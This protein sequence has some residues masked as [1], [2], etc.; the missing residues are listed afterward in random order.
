MVPEQISIR[1]PI[2]F[3][4]EQTHEI[5]TESIYQEV[6]RR[7]KRDGNGFVKTGEV[8]LRPHLTRRHKVRAKKGFRKAPGGTGKRISSSFY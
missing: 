8:D 5:A 3:R 7:V 2:E 1:L 4:E 6:Y